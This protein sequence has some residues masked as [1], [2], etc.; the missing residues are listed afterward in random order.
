[1]S[2]A[3]YRT[4]PPREP[5]SLPVAVK[6]DLDGDEEEKTV[7]AVKAAPPWL[8][9]LVF[10]MIVLIVLGLIFMPLDLNK[11]VELLVQYAE[12]EGVQ[13]EDDL[14]DTSL[15]EDLQIPEPVLAVD[16]Q[17]VDDPLAAPPIVDIP[18]DGVGARH[19][20]DRG[21]VDRHGPLRP[22]ERDEA[23]AASAPT[24]APPRPRR[25]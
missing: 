7:E 9:S 5:G 22:G 1:M 8:V 18:L 4:A 25:P 12:E 16:M 11:G 13:L 19:E 21:A 10:H 3:S 15:M 23:G 2:L 20:H 6:E 14:L 17:P 24:A